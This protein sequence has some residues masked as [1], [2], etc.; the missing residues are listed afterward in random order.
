MIILIANATAAGQSPPV[1]IP[2]GE[3]VTVALTGTYSGSE[4]ADIQYNANGT[5]KDL[6]QSA[7]QQRLGS[8]NNAVRIA[9]PIGIRIDKDA[10]VAA[11]GAVLFH[12]KNGTVIV[13]NA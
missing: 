1:S 12:D 2:D 4:F 7:A 10:T 8:T 9:G 3:S 11:T 13:G 6:F 5:W